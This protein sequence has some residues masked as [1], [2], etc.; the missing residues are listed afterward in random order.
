[1]GSGQEQRELA[2]EVARLAEGH[3]DGKLYL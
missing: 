3:H 1:V 2:E